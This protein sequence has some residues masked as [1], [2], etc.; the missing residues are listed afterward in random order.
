MTTAAKR[1]Q[2]IDIARGI[3]II[4]VV[5]AHA[6]RGLVLS[7]VL[8]S[9]GALLAVDTVIYSFHMPL[10]FI[11]AGLNIERSVARGRKNFIFN[12]LETIAWPYFLW[13]LVQ[14]AM[15]LAATPYT[16]N[17]ITRSDL[18]A[19]PIAPIEQFWFLYVL[20]FCQLFITIVLP[21]RGLLAGLSFLG[22][23][24]WVAIADES[25]FFRILHYLPYVVAGLFA[26]PFFSWMR[27]RPAAQAAILAGAWLAFLLLTIPI[28]PPAQS[29]VLIYALAFLGSAGTIAIAMLLEVSKLPIGWL[30]Y[31]G[32]LSMPIFLMHT[33]FSAAMRA[34][35]N[36]AGFSDPGMTLG[37]VTL[38]GI[39]LPLPVYHIAVAL[40][41]NRLLGF[42]A[43]VDR[44]KGGL[45]ARQ[46]FAVANPRR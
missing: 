11:L 33:V 17:P 39:L 13:S 43:H 12:K 42:G 6:A 22:V 32:R 35:L 2:W 46:P 16:N 38:A 20:F 3:G 31:L 45:F 19:I 21:R 24:T 4:L 10:F 26:V 27:E 18:V 41:I 23:V 7:K 15:K 9:G 28:G 37:L 8:P 44:N 1:I 5:Y 34:G 36:I 25:I 30:E 14:G 40:K 29:A